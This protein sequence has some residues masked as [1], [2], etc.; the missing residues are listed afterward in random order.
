M[1]VVSVSPQ[2]EFLNE[3]LYLAQETDL[4]LESADGTQ[5]FLAH[6][7]D[8]QA[9]YIGDDDDFD[10]EII[11]TRKN[12]RLMKFLDERG[13]KAKSRKGRPLAEVRRQ[14]GL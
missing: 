2:A 8:A 3:L 7:T 13:A 1:K 5:F 11:A 9:F 14:L 10:Q 12:E 4:I 6:I